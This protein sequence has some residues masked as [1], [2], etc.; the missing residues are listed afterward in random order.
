M[1]LN[2]ER[3]RP[4]KEYSI[5]LS[6]SGDSQLTVLTKVTNSKFLFCVW[7]TESWIPH[8]FPLNRVEKSEIPQT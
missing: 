3:I 8:R 4:R 1:R 5:R 6:A 2:Y 7:F